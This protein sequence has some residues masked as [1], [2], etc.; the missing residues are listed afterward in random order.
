MPS[1]L[2]SA[3]AL[4]Y[5]SNYLSIRCV[6]AQRC[7]S[8][9]TDKRLRVFRRQVLVGVMALGCGALSFASL[10]G[11]VTAMAAGFLAFETACGVYF[12]R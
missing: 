6:V 11:S 1:Q 7:S 4:P 8:A 2:A 10:G 12:P 5:F 9:V 3:T